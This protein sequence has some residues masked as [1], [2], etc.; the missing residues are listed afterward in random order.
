MPN[1]K[2]HE[3]YS[4]M[5]LNQYTPFLHYILDKPAKTMKH[6]HRALYHDYKTV[7]LIEQ[8]YGIDL[9]LESLLHIIVDLESIK[10]ESKRLVKD[11]SL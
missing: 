5:Y 9:A 11:L 1:R 2:T 10:P 4:L 6:T 7:Q 8:L 3:K